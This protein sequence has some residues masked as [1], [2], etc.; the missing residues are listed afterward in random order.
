VLLGVGIRMMDN[1][2]KK[3]RIW[4]GFAA[5]MVL[6]EGIFSCVCKEDGR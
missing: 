6:C 4:H 2:S 1:I 3:W 5:C